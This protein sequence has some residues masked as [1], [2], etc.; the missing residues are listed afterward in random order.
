L[1][2]F[3]AIVDMLLGENFHANLATPLAQSLQRCPG[4][5]AATQLDWLP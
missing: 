4:L 1:G 2:Y 5:V 3:C